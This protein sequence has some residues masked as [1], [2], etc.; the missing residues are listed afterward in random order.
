ML[1]GMP[2]ITER[3]PSLYFLKPLLTLLFILCTESIAEA[4]A[5]IQKVKSLQ[6][7]F[8]YNWVAP[9]KWTAAT[10]VNA[11]YDF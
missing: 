3:T 4:N 2:C 1:P 11:E 6:Y 7:F 10:Q 5:L 9:I 8:P